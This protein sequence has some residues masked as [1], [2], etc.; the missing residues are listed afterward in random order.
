MIFMHTQLQKKETT[1]G[2]IVSELMILLI[3][4]LFPFS[5]WYRKQ[6]MRL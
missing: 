6:W 5:C 4:I 3:R 2:E 1:P